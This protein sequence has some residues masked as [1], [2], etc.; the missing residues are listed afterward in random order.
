MPKLFPA[1]F[2][3][4][5]TAALLLLAGCDSPA[6]DEPRATT[7][8]PA[9]KTPAS[10]E[11]VGTI[12][13]LEKHTLLG[14]TSTDYITLTFDEYRLR[15]EVRPRGFADSTERYGIVADLRFDSLTYYLQDATQNV[16]CRL[17]RA[18][19]LARV[20]ANEPILASLD[21]RP[22]SAIF[23][24]LPAGTPYKTLKTGV[25]LGSLADC[26]V[27][28]FLLPGQGSCEAL[29]SGRVRVSAQKLAYIEYQPPAALPSLALTVH[30]TAPP[31]PQASTML[32]RLKHRLDHVSSAV[33][34]FNSWSTTRPSDQDFALPTA[35]RY[36]GSADALEAVLRGP[37][38]HSHHHHH[39]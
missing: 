5:A 39:H 2:A 25:T 26:R 15:R 31:K 7:V 37:S 3:T 4:A 16:H 9:G 11:F 21:R 29:Y 18:D 28:L 20:A 6:T 17:A 34:E 14:I 33:T 12:R 38:S 10:G 1:P 22:Y 36:A 23:A 32:E 19:Y 27:I 8:Q 30:Y 13:L 24:P 35:S